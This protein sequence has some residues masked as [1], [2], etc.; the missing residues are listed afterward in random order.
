MTGNTIDVILY[1]L[2]TISF[3]A[4]TL[5]PPATDPHRLRLIAA[6]G[7]FAVLSILIP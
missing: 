1:I 2:S 6:G 5:A 7:F 3:G 4:A